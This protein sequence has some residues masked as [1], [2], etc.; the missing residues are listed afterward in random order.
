MKS[1]SV[2]KHNNVFQQKP[3]FN[4]SVKGSLSILYRRPAHTGV[5][6]APPAQ[7]KTTVMQIQC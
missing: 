5:L 7:L 4:F 1:A 3:D 2:V 6:L